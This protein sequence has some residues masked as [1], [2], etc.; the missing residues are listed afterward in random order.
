MAREGAM[1]C[2]MGGVGG[3]GRGAVLRYNERAKKTKTK[4]TRVR[5]Q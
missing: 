4:T 3:S 5:I 1:G 2:F